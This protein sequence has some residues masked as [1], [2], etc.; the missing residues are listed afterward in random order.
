MLQLT[1]ILTQDL[2]LL[3]RI[4]QFLGERQHKLCNVVGVGKNQ[5]RL[6]LR[7]RETHRALRSTDQE[8]VYRLIRT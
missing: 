2:L 3:G 6:Q 4:N 5:L 1:C 8:E 7:Y